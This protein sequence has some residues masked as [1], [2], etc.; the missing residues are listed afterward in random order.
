MKKASKEASGGSEGWGD[1]GRRREVGGGEW[2]GG[3]AGRR[4][5]IG[6]EAKPPFAILE[7]RRSWSAR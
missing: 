4:R 1:D 7:H 6:D 2:S 3:E 5:K